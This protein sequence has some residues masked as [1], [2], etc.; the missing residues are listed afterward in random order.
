MNK[1]GEILHRTPLKELFDLRWYIQPLMD[2]NE[3]E[4]PRSGRQ[5]DETD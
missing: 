1:H 2:E 3:N 4:N 5:L